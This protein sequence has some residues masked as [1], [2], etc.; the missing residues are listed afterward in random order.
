MGHSVHH[1]YFADNT[2]TPKGG[3]ER[4]PDDSPHL[5][6]EGLHIDRDFTRHKHSVLNRRQADLDYGREVEKRVDAF[7]P[8]VVISA[9]MPLDAQ[10]ILQQATRRHK[11]RFVFWL[12]DVYCVAARFFLRKK[13][14]FL[15]RAGGYYFERL[16]K[17]LLHQSDAVVCIAPGFAEFIRKWEIPDSK[18]HVI[19]NW[20]PLHEVVPT[21]RMNPWARENGVADRFCFMYSGTLGT[22]HRPE[23]LLELGKRLEARGDARLIVIAAGPGADWLRERAQ[24]VSPDFLTLLPF[25]PYERISEV[26]GSADVLI[27]LLDSEAGAFAVP[28][29]TLSY[30][31]AGRAVMV[32]APSANEAARLVEEAEAGLVVSPDEPQQ[33]VAAAERFLSDSQLC[34]RC[35]IN[36]RRYAEQNFAIETIAARFQ[37]VL[38]GEAVPAEIESGNLVLASA[39]SERDPSWQLP[40]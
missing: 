23:L 22:K 21:P 24:E 30:L 15:A 1:V 36:A 14:R 13:A 11:A 17:K 5:V 12:Q 19:R 10:N 2:L 7:R 37:A 40:A 20:A 34:A 16:E 26:L 39:D 29:K 32:A 31:C 27:T 18:I 28:S 3:T 4:R 9:N 35:G 25:Q 8:D 6:I 38:S 33:F